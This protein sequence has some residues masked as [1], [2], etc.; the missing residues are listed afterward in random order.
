M[1]GFTWVNVIAGYEGSATHGVA[2][3]LYNWSSAAWDTFDAIEN[4]YADV[5]T[6]D[7]YIL[8]NHD[9][10]VPSDTNYIGTGAND[11]DVRVRIYHTPLGNASH[12]TYI[13]VV[14]L[15]L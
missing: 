14:A 5:T 10:V 1:T 11:G 2:L 6:A 8:S 9:F 13:D 7:G 12:D 15:Y 3:Q 4:G